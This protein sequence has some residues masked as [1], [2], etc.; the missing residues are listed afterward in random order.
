M[1]FLVS[2][3]VRLESFQAIDHLYSTICNAIMK[4]ASLFFRLMTFL[5]VATTIDQAMGPCWATNKSRNVIEQSLVIKA[6]AKL[7]FEGIQMSRTADPDRRHLVSHHED[8]AIID[9]K[10]T[11]LPI[12][13]MAHL[14]YKEIEVPFKRIDYLLVSS[15]K[16]KAFEGSWE[17]T[18]LENGRETKVSLKSYS[19]LKVWMP[20]AKELGNSSTVKD[21]NR[22]LHNLKHWC[23]EQDVKEAKAHQNNQSDLEHGFAHPHSQ[24]HLAENNVHSKVHAD[25]EEVNGGEKYGEVLH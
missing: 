16:F 4:Q 13:G 18:P 11:D 20:L 17:L 15:D 10:I 9:E 3:S 21:I 25:A 5:I 23:D 22:R 1:P 7:V 24:S 2:C 6:P 19:D 14:I 8:V 12:I